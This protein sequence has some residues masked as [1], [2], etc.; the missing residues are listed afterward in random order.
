MD[1]GFCHRASVRTCGKVTIVR[2]GG[3]N[4]FDRVKRYVP[5]FYLCVFPLCIKFV[6]MNN[7]VTIRVY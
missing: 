5:F 3:R 7:S 1:R 2:G 6:F 4:G